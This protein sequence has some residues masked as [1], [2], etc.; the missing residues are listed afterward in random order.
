MLQAQKIALQ[1]LANLSN[2]DSQYKD[3]LWEGF[4]SDHLKNIVAKGLCELI[5]NSWTCTFGMLAEHLL[6][7]DY[8]KKNPPGSVEEFPPVVFLFH[9]L[10]QHFH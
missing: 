3:Q 1:V 6:E 5:D 9:A 8:A 4:F 2:Q 7:V 10:V